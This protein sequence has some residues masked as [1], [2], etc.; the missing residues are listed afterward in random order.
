MTYI[1][2]NCIS[3]AIFCFILLIDINKR[4]TLKLLLNSKALACVK[5][6]GG[7]GFIKIK[8]VSFQNVRL[9]KI[10]NIIIKQELKMSQITSPHKT[11]LKWHQ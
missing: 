6:R 4:I 9:K 11:F 1:L 8:G 2:F 7:G 5:K 10:L 3:N